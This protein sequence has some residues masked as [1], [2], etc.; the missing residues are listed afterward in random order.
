[1]HKRIYTALLVAILSGCRAGPFITKIVPLGDGRLLVHT[2]EVSTFTPF[3]G[4]FPG[5]WSTHREKHLVDTQ[6][7]KGRRLEF[8]IRPRKTR[9]RRF[10]HYIANPSAMTRTESG[11]WITTISGVDLKVDEAAGERMVIVRS[12]LPMTP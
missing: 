1:M 11:W 3:L 6:S 7:G 8:Y 9:K 10:I 2:A 12:F 5:T 4:F